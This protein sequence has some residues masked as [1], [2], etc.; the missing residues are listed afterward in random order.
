MI[1]LATM[2]IYLYFLS[3]ESSSDSD[4][5]STGSEKD[6]APTDLLPAPY[7]DPLPVD[8]A[9][10]QQAHQECH[11]QDNRKVSAC[12]HGHSIG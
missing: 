1:L 10:D 9:V 5:S 12:M 4:Q 11:E 6:A 7:A 2:E 3:P 8:P